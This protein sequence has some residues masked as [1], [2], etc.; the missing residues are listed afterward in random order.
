MYEDD[1]IEDSGQPLEFHDD[2]TSVDWWRLAEIMAEAN[3]F[4]RKPFDI[5]R[6]FHGSYASVI[7]YRA[8]RLIA[9]ARATSDGVFYAT[10]FDVVVA[11][12]EQSQG[13]GRALMQALLAKLPFER[14]FLKSVPDRKGFYRKLGF[15]DQTNAMGLY[16][17]GARERALQW[18]VLVEDTR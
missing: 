18:G 7:V 13:V 10:V 15:L 11:P 16:A 8:G 9:A 12:D 5:A 14:V 1:D 3:L 2:L 4:D 17:D 6:A